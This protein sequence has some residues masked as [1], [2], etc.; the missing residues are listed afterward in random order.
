MNLAPAAQANPS[1]SE[2][3]NS[4]NSFFIILEFTFKN[5]ISDLVYEHVTNTRLHVVTAK[6]FMYII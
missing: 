6:N 1:E 3:F 2:S 4:G 5:A